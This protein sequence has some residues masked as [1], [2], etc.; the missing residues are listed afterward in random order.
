[1]GKKEPVRHAVA[2]GA[3]GVVAPA[4]TARVGSS[5]HVDKE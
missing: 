2:A 3:G 5:T 4:H 1:M